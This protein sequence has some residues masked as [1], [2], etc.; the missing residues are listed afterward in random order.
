MDLIRMGFIIENFPCCM[1]GIGDD[2][3]F[4]H[5]LFIACLVDTAP[6]NKEFSFSTSDK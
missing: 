6:N 1:N 4:E 5:I 2:D 3:N